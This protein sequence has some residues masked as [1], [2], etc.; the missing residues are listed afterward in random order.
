MTR[1]SFWRVRP[2]EHHWGTEVGPLDRWLLLA[3]LLLALWG[4]LIVYSSSSAM[5]VV[6]HG[7]N[8]LFYLES[9]LAKALFGVGLMF[10]L[11]RLGVPALTG[12]IAWGVWGTALLVLLVMLLPW[13][14]G[15]EVRGAR[16]WLA[17]GGSMV[18]PAE[19]A[20]V[21]MVIALAAWLAH[22]R[23][24]LDRWK[25][26]LPAY[27]LVLVTAGLIAMQPHLSLALLTAGSGV[28]LI[29][30]AG[31]PLGKLALLTVPSAA[32]LLLLKRGY[33]VGRL[34][35]FLAGIDG[36]PGYQVRQSMLSIGSGGL[37]GLGLG[38]GMQKH[39]FLP[40]PHTDFILSIIG[41]ELGFVGLVAL[42]LLAGWI[43][44]RIFAI[45][46]RASLAVG[47]FLA[48]GVG[49][50]FLLAF[51]L[52]A[53]VCLGWAPTTGVPFPLV[54]F[55]GSALIAHL[56]GIGLVLAVSRRAL[57]ARHGPEDALLMQ[58]PHW[59]R[60]VS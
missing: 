52:H 21:A 41:E 25:G 12:R 53:A 9:Q 31:A 38:Q 51:L 43:A 42:F 57:R 55:G 14:P 3:V 27:A 29:Y 4:L 48:Y 6:S 11:S 22:H 20:R 35:G 18:Q 40:D 7:G 37:T 54:S 26:L 2:W 16:R 15:V 58:E 23:T 5:G 47:E 30:L 49:L 1:G 45:G 17:V 36:D 59:G 56:I 8:D 10:A 19:F 34:S 33:Q 46:R 13:G 50:Q 44:W 24:R 60:G 28:L 39:F 32:V